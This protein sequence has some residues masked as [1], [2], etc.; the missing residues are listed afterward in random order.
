MVALRRTTRLEAGSSV[1]YAPIEVYSEPDDAKVA[2]ISVPAAR[3]GVLAILEARPASQTAEWVIPSRASALALVYGPQGL[4]LSKVASMVLRDRDLVPQLADYAEK[5]AQTEVLLETVAAWERNGSGQSLE[6]ALQG[7]SSRYGVAFPVLDRTASPDKQALTL[8]RALHPALST[9]DPLAPDAGQRLQQSAGLAASVAGLFFGN[10]VGL[11][12][13]GGAMFLNLRSLLFPGSDFRSA[14]AHQH[15]SGLTLCAKREASKSR[16]RLVYL[17]AWRIEDA[18]R[19]RIE[20]LPWRVNPGEPSRITLRGQGL[21]RIRSVSIA[22]GTTTYNAEDHTLEVTVPLTAAKGERIDVQMEIE[23]APVAQALNGAIE[24][25]GPR[26][27]LSRP[28]VAVPDDLT[29]SLA[30]GELP[31][32][33]YTSISFRAEHA[34]SLPTLQLECADPAQ[35]LGKLSLRP[36]EQAGSAR[37]RRAGGHGLFLSFDPGSVGQPGCQLTAAI[38]TTDGRSDPVGIGAIVRLPKIEAFVLS[39][40]SAGGGAYLGSLTGEELESI[41]KTG[42]HERDGLEVRSAPQPVSST[43]RRHRI[44]IAMPWPPPAPRAPVYVWLRGEQ[45]G[46]RTKVRFAP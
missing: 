31:A 44:R 6:S 32:G 37:L 30:A 40:E 42:W 43:D 21:E 3:D 38:E 12:A 7:F 23:D 28:E 14:L 24:V 33:S 11:A 16:T 36:G 20:G 25:L 19:P 34:G 5:S 46:R 22:R 1:V 39:D 45:E 8:M 9:I 29:V 17:W 15:S 10:T 26:P 18:P 13:T 27:K 35:T 2:L 41:E 4:D